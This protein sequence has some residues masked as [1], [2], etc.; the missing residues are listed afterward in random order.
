MPRDNLIDN[1]IINNEGTRGFV[2]VMALIGISGFI[3]FVFVIIFFI[4]E[5]LNITPSI[6]VFQLPYLTEGENW[7]VFMLFFSLS[8]FVPLLILMQIFNSVRTGVR[9][10]K[11]KVKS[12]KSEKT[13][14]NM[15]LADRYKQLKEKIKNR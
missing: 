13:N 11:E 4:G 7:I 15:T 9:K 6:E 12:K 2:K 10:T 3:A 1:E 14:K 5:K 8:I